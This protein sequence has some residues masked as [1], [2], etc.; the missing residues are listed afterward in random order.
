MLPD[1]QSLKRDIQRILDRYLQTQVHARLGVFNESP[2]HTIHEGNRLRTIRADG[3]VE[4]S[5]LKEASAEVML[6]LDEIPQLTIEQR[7]AKIND[8][9]DKMAQQMNEHLFGALNATLDKAGQVVD[10]QGK[11]LDVDAVFKVLEKIQLDFD[12]A[13]KPDQLS[14]VVHPTLAP[15]AKLVFEKIES[16]PVLRERYEEI[17]VRK[18]FEWRDREADRK[19]VG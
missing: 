2:H 19:L 1:L 17:I 7:V 8:M 3:S 13:G 11:P 5:N 16:D 9:A 15:Q 18:R 4:D 6:K 10:Q 12:E 14:I